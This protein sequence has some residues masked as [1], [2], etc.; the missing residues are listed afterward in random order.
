MVI[1]RY[2]L[3]HSLISV[4]LLLVDSVSA[5]PIVRRIVRYLQE[6][7]AEAFDYLAGYNFKFERTSSKESY[8]AASARYLGKAYLHSNLNGLACSAN[9]S[10][11]SC[12][13]QK[14]VNL[15]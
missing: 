9:L 14:A 5:I 3:F 12:G 7:S 6:V 1:K 8:F 2:G 4:A 11:R 15:H 10:S 13:W